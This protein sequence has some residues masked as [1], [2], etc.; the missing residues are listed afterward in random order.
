M[1]NRSELIKQDK[2][3][4]SYKKDKSILPIEHEIEQKLNAVKYYEGL[5]DAE[6][7]EFKE[8]IKKKKLR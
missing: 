4:K 6:K 3:R 5:S 8:E 1:V 7:L 2:K